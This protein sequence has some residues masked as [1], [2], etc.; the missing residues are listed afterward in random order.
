[1]WVYGALRVRD[2]KALTL[3]APSRNTKGYLRLLEAVTESK[4]YPDDLYPIT[5]D[6]SSRK[7]PPIREWLENHPR[8]KQVFI[9]V[10]ARWLDLQEAWWRLFRRGALAGQS[11]AD[12]SEIESAN[13]VGHEGSYQ[14]TQPSSKTLV[15]GTTTQ[16]AEALEALFCLPPSR[17]GAVEAISEP[18]LTPVLTDAE[19]ERL[20][21]LMPPQKPPT[22]RPRRDHRIWCWPEYYG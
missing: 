3:T 14:A 18:M 19:W 21:P 1:V 5:D 2:G 6:L 17:N 4:P 12:A 9:P 11:F 8:V 7:S 20:R 10:G 16:T 13:R 15:M 22:G